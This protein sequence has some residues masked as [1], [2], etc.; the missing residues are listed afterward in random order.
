MR[1][2]IERMLELGLAMSLIT[3]ALGSV[4]K[5]TQSVGSLIESS[6]EG[7][8]PQ[9][10]EFSPRPNTPSSYSDSLPRSE[11]LDKYYLASEFRRQSEVEAEEDFVFID[12][13]K[14][15]LTKEDEGLGLEDDRGVRLKAEEIRPLL[16]SDSEKGLSFRYKDS[17]ISKMELH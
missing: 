13:I 10:L 11:T 16:D 1:E 14:I 6:Y 9:T 7:R 3:L 12:G 4:Y 5:I 17:K 15:S 2:H 8:R